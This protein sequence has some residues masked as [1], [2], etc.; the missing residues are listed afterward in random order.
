MN[1]YTLSTL[2]DDIAELI[3]AAREF[4]KLKKAIKVE[5]KAYGAVSAHLVHRLSETLAIIG[6]RG[7]GISQLGM[8]NDDP[9]ITNIVEGLTK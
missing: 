9:D 5:K 1:D 2:E 7:T 6:E 3:S 8:N 4:K